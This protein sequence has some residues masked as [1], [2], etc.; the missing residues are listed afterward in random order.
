MLLGFSCFSQDEA[1]SHL[2]DIYMTE[3]K[4]KSNIAELTINLSKS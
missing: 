1:C 3:D 4:I 2:C